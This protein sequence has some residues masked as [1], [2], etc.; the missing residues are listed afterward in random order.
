MEKMDA[1]KEGVWGVLGRL[2]FKA[3]GV[4]VMPVSLFRSVEN[5]TELAVVN[6]GLDAASGL[7]RTNA[8]AATSAAAVTS[9]AAAVDVEEV[10]AEEADELDDE[11]PALIPPA[12]ETRLAAVEDRLQAVAER[13]RKALSGELVEELK[14]AGREADAAGLAQLSAGLEQLAHH[15]RAGELLRLKY[16]LQ[17]HRQVAYRVGVG[18][19]FDEKRQT[20]IIKAL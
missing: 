2:E 14:E 15:R 4:A 6:V 9:A 18:G 19:A 3:G 16:L 20:P 7:K 8:P 5:T 17:L 12:L 13:G 1:A 10:D 11:K